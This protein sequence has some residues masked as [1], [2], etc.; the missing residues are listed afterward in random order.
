MTDNKPPSVALHPS[1]RGRVI[2]SPILLSNIDRSVGTKNNLA[3]QD[4]LHQN[5]AL[6]FKIS[7]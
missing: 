7:K 2:F 5:H 4:A 6:V 1:R 3:G